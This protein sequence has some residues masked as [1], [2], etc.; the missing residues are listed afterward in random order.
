MAENVLETRI[1]LRY[2]T[3]QQ[4]MNSN[5]I[6]LQGEAAI[7]AFP[8][9]KTIDQMSDDS[10]ANTPPAIGIKI[11]DG[12]HRFDELPWV[13]AVAADVFNWAKQ[14]TKPIYTAQEIQGLQN[15]IENLV[16]GETE[17]SIAPRIYQLI[18]GT[19]EN[20]DKYYL[21]YKEN[22]EDSA[23]IIDTSSYIDLQK[24]TTLYNWIGETNIEEYRSMIV[25]NAEQIRYFIDQMN[26]ADS[27]VNKRFVTSVSQTSGIINVERD[28]ITFDDLLGTATVSQGGTG[29]TTLDEDKVLVGNGANAIKLIPIAEEVANNNYLVP[30]RLMK[31]Y[32]DTATAGLTGAMHFIGEATV[33]ITNNSIVNPQINGYDFS[34]VSPGDVILYNSKEFV[35]TGDNWRL[36]GDEGSYAIKGSIR[37]ADIDP[38]AGIA[39]SKIANLDST[40]STKVD[41]VAGKSLTSNDFTD[42]LYNKLLQIEDGAQRNAIEHIFLNGTEITPTTVNQ[43]MRSVNLTINLFTETD[44]AKLA[45]IEEGAQV[46]TIE[47]VYINGIQQPVNNKE[48]RITIDQAALNLN[49]LEGAQVPAVTGGN[50]E[51]VPQIQKKLQLARIALTGNIENLSQTDDTYILLDC[52][53]STTVI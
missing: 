16:S 34:K 48:V 35:W 44:Q 33:V 24:L 39:Q 51:E 7:C 27:P 47:T 38:D 9:N 53:T 36:L 28:N 6:L 32:V 18:R 15:F 11:G 17:I 40:F 20:A 46:N 50:R 45:G 26:K 13:Q 49:V 22:T 21:Q 37:D 1:L 42:E 4:W 41:K 8:R 12:Y 10:P 25:R 30:N 52:G 31:T 23:W 2:G 43:L 29:R 3:Y 19:G 5:V 14:E